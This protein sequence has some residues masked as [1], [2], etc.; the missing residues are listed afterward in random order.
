MKKSD[1]LESSFLEK[2]RLGSYST[3]HFVA[4]LSVR[5][6]CHVLQCNTVA[7]FARFDAPIWLSGV[8]VE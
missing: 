6:F 1:A 5:I 2:K 4:P 8:I 3:G 7:C